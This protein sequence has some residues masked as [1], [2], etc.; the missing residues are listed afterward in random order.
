MQF[1]FS[2]FQKNFANSL[3]A[4]T[5]LCTYVRMVSTVWKLQNFS[6]TLLREVNV[7]KL[8]VSKFVLITHCE[9]L[10]FYIYE[11]FNFFEGLKLAIQQNSEPIKW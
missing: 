2:N 7:G 5:Q 9:A 11:F 10:N 8:R 4:S 1:F 6:V 3:P